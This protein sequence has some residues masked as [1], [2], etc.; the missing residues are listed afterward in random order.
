MF[1]TTVTDLNKT[2]N[3]NSNNLNTSILITPTKNLF[4]EMKFRK[5][6][7]NLNRTQ[8]VE[9]LRDK[10]FSFLNSYNSNKNK[11]SNKKKFIDPNSSFVNSKKNLNESFSFALKSHKSSE[12][13]Y[14]RKVYIRHNFKLRK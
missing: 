4:S 5:N 1:S 14:K 13:F 7:S 9:N 2:Y 8:T 6:E 11:N 10:G 12:N 3:Y